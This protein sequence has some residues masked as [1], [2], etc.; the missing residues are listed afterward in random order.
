MKAQTEGGKKITITIKTSSVES[1]EVAL[2]DTYYLSHILSHL[3]YSS[4]AEEPLLSLGGSLLLVEKQCTSTKCLRDFGI[5]DAAVLFLTGHDLEDHS[6]KIEIPTPI[7]ELVSK[8]GEDGPKEASF[9]L[10][11]KHATRSLECCDGFI[12]W[13]CCRSAPLSSQEEA[14]STEMA[15]A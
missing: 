7:N 13:T 8:Y 11:E 5:E 4:T 12:S 9:M 6:Q 15:T 3:P 10:E 14:A 2:L 1:M